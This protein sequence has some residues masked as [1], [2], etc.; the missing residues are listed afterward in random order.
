[1]AT[2]IETKV[3][4]KIHWMAPFQALDRAIASLEDI[5]IAIL[6]FGMLSL[7]SIQIVMWNVFHQGLPWVDPLL[8]HL[9]LWVAMVGASM[10]TSARRHLNM[11]TLIHLL[12]P[13]AKA[14]AGILVELSS[15]VIIGI[16]A[17]VSC[18]FIGEEMAS[19]ATAFLNVARWQAELILPIAFGTM[20]YRF[21]LSAIED[22]RNLLCPQS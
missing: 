3:A 22:L 20:S 2:V 11:D 16:L 17:W 10:A 12:P 8:R 18:I 21:L 5:V 13:R 4:G 6:L 7:G 9:V 19:G 15:A 14:I 1:M